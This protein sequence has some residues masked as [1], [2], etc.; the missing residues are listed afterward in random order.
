MNIKGKDIIEAMNRYRGQRYVLGALP[1]KNFPNSAGPW[2]CAELCSYNIYALANKPYGVINPK[3]EV[4]RWDSWTGQWR[5]DSDK[6]GKII[7]VDEAANTSGA[8]V[9]RFSGAS[10]GHI[11]ACQGDG[12]TIEAH[13]SKRG[14]INAQV[15]GRRWDR[16]ILVFPELIDYS[17][18]G[19]CVIAPPTALVFRYRVPHMQHKLIG[20]MQ[21][22]LRGLKLYNYPLQ[23]GKETFKYGLQTEKAV[24]EYQTKFGLVIDGEAGPETLGHMKLL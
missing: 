19:K 10:I 7:T 24:R 2:D 22:I 15:S 20:E 16:G 3:A 23:N 12:T 1:F 18:T 21:K 9:L 13:S 11:A 17:C 4:S 6:L 8:F 5:A 14:V